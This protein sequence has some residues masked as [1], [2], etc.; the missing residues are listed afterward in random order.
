MALLGPLP[1]LLADLALRARLNRGTYGRFY[2]VRSTLLAD[3][4]L[5]ARLNRGIYGRFYTV[6]STAHRNGVADF[7]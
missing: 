4:A 1:L 5:R 2:T 6:R 3:L 7:G